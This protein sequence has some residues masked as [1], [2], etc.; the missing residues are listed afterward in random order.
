MVVVG[1]WCFGS[2]LYI[3]VVDVFGVDN[4]G[5]VWL[6]FDCFGEECQVVSS[7]GWGV[8]FDCFLLF[9]FGGGVYDDCGGYVWQLFCCWFVGGCLRD[10]VSVG[11]VV[12]V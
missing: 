8:Y 12:D 4:G 11:G 5:C 3:V 1:E 10:V 6:G 7:F 9:V 2:V